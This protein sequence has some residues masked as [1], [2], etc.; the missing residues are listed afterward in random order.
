MRETGLEGEFGRHSRPVSSGYRSDGPLHIQV[1]F[2]LTLL[3]T[4]LSIKTHLEQF[5]ILRNGLKV[6]DANMLVGGFLSM[7]E[8]TSRQNLKDWFFGSKSIAI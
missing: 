5:L 2:R 1:L 3:F 8:T 4:K 7:K 6:N